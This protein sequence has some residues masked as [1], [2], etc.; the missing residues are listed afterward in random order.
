MT[1]D[2]MLRRIAHGEHS[3]PLRAGMRKILQKYQQVHG[4]SPS[5]QPDEATRE[6]LRGTSAGPNSYQRMFERAR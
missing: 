4:L 5:G 6:H 2:Q 1:I 3:E